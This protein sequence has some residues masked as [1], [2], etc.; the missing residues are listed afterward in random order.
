VL[1]IGATVTANADEARIFAVADAAALDDPYPDR[2]THFPDQVIG[3]ADVTYSTLPGF[4]PLVV[5]IYRPMRHD[6]AKPLVLYIHGGGWMNGHT[7]HL[8]A[9]TD[10]PAVL[11]R[12]A[13]EGFVV[14]SPEYRL[15]G[16]A[17][18]PAALQ[19]ARA[20]LRF[21][22]ANAAKYGIDP[23]RTGVFGGSAGGHLA[24]LTALT[25]GDTSLDPEPAPA[26]SECV[27]AVV[28][29]YGAFDF[30]P[31]VA[32]A[33]KDRSA[34]DPVLKFLGCAAGHCTAAAIERAS[35]INRVTAKAPPF[36]L[37][38][39]EADAVV[40]VQQS[41]AFEAQLAA[42]GV[43]V[44]AIYIGGAGHSWIGATP[45]DTRSATLRATNATFDFFRSELGGLTR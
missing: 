19:D 10:F 16:E 2:I 21:L 41:H 1:L 6:N 37:I 36:L 15:S 45:A 31:I 35:P 14:A 34:D 12:L 29:W 32:A 23:T 3:L 42:A 25:C 11:A 40:P 43:P 39:G 27:Q 22:K 8:G 4:R 24:A 17:P 7:R 13:S 5:D 26:G 44:E 38:H 28:T 33:A 30:A 20:A 18:F 9:L